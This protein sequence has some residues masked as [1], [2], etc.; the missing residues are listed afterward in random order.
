[1][2]VGGYDRVLYSL[3]PK[4]GKENGTG[5]W[6]FKE[7]KNHYVGSPLVSDAGIFAPNADDHL[8]A[9]DLK[10]NL[11]W[12]F[13][14]QGAQWAAPVTNPGCECVY[15]PS[16]D[17]RLYAIDAQTGKTKW[18]TDDLGGS[19]VGTPAY[20]PEG[21]LYI[22]TFNSEMLAVNAEN[23]GI[24]W[25]K[26]TDGWVW[27]GPVLKEGKLYYGDLSGS[28]YA[29][30]AATGAVAWKIKPDGP[31]AQSPLLAEEAIYFT[32]QAGSVYAIDYAGNIRWNK[33]IG[34]KLYTSPAL[35]GDKILVA[36]T[37]LDAYLIALD[38]NGA[39][40]WQFIPEKK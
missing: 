10:G 20:S 11:R 4:N 17:H 27:G 28:F 5:N 14:T 25:Q 18:Q 40:V 12:P 35:A 38:T 30:E 26:P 19:M 32:T 37:G 29:M 23:G 36:P 31:I 33:T 34:G 3:D 22:G 39:Q 2:L 8:Y 9:L 1:L 6:P 16:M 24:L 15:L 13:Q 21:V 7:A